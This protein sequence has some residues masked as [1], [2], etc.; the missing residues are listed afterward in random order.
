MSEPRPQHE[1]HAG[2][3]RRDQAPPRVGRPVAGHLRVA[4]VGQCVPIAELNRPGVAAVVVEDLCWRIALEA[5]SL[6]VRRPSRPDRDVDDG[7]GP[8]DGRRPP[9]RCAHRSG[10]GPCLG[11]VDIEFVWDQPWGMGRVL[12][13]ARQQLGVM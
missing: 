2:M 12:D 8:R 6:A 7:T 10:V 4:S 9:R 3:T 1:P 13:A 11:G 5:E